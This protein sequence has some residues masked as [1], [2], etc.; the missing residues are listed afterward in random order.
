MVP[1]DA[2]EAK[3]NISNKLWGCTGSSSIRH[4]YIAPELFLLLMTS[5]FTFYRCLLSAIIFCLCII[6]FLLVVPVSY[7][8]H[9]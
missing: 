8:I 7:V 4:E 2:N 9:T 5:L 6:I 3:K 1:D